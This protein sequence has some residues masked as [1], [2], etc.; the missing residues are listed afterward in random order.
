VALFLALI[1]L[2]AV[3]GHAVAMW[4][5]EL[6]LRM[7]LGA[8]AAQVGWLVLALAAAMLAA[9][10]AYNAF[11]KRGPWAWTAYSVLSR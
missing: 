3:T 10:M 2:Y 8:R 5:R 6:G 7:A 9:G 4:T 11:L 1:G